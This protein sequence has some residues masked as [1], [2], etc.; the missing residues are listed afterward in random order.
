MS[1]D[2]DRHQLARNGKRPGVGSGPGGWR[3]ECVNETHYSDASVGKGQ[4]P[5]NDDRNN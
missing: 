5:I 4:R 3:D 2:W 1:P